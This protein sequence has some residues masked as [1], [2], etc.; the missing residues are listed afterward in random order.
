MNL[1]KLAQKH[2]NAYDKLDKAVFAQIAKTPEYVD[3]INRV[4]EEIRG[5]NVPAAKTTTNKKLQAAIFIGVTAF[6]M[7]VTGVD[8][9]LAE[10]AR[11]QYRKFQLWWASVPEP[12]DTATNGRHEK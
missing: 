3:V 8:L 7:H 9:I 2:I 1:E 6:T 5:R 10:K 11:H 4:D 12:V